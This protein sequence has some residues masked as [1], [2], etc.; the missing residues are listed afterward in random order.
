M[1][2]A[3]ITCDFRYLS[4]SIE[5]RR[6]MAGTWPSD[7]RSSIAILLPQRPLTPDEIDALGE[8]LKRA[9]R[10]IQTLPLPPEAYQPRPREQR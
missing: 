2:V 5:A 9:C 6:L 8:A 7:D 3:I 4:R 1:D 10:D